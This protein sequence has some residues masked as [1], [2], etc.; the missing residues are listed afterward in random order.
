MDTKGPIRAADLQRTLYNTGV[1]HLTAG[2]VGPGVAL[3]TEAAGLAMLTAQAGQEGAAAAALGL[4]YRMLGDPL[5]ALGH[6]QQALAAARRGGQRD[7]EQ[8]ALCDLGNLYAPVNPALAI[9]YYEA[10]LALARSLG[11]R[12]A[13]GA[14]A[15]NL[16]VACHALGAT[17]RALRLHQRALAIARADGAWSEIKRAVSNLGLA[18]V[19]VR[20]LA[21]ARALLE[22]HVY[23]A[24]AV[25]DRAAEARTLFYLGIVQV[26]GDPEQAAMCFRR[27]LDLAHDLGQA[28][29][30]ALASY[31]LAVLL[32]SL[33]RI[34]EAR[35]YARQA[36]QH[37]GLAGQARALLARMREQ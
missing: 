10:A 19:T 1:A 33:G 8:V 26:D 31:N 36:L 5:R 2:R 4:A 29:N 20:R 3:L 32:V 23:A 12:A 27:A 14:L 37:A 15:G 22:E 11:D 30:A 6:A 21:E 34:E 24:H 25:G 18:L 9:P 16:G 7:S 17:T 13:E 35:P 28:A